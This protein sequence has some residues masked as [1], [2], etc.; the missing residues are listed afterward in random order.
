MTRKTVR[1]LGAVLLVGA[2]VGS[3]GCTAM[4]RR[5]ELPKEDR[6]RTVERDGATSVK[7]E[8]E[9]AVG[10][11]KVGSVSDRDVAMDGEFVYSR[12]D[13]APRVGY[14]L[15]GEVG[16]L[17]VRQDDVRGSLGSAYH[18][19]WDVRL[20]DDLPIDLSVELGVGESELNLGELQLSRLDAD[21]GVG[22]ATIDLSG[23]TEDLAA[24]IDCGTGSVTLR[25]PEN[26]GVRIVG[27]SD[28]IGEYSA[29]GFEQD[30]DALVN[31]AYEKD[32]AK[33]DIVLRRGVGD[34]RI[35]TVP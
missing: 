20:P 11:L 15:D 25:V 17:K 4:F 26:V 9:M 29:P 27:Q 35:E 10:E 5:V 16:E 34:V 22:D 18:N 24:E 13:W 28:G 23:L 3:T 33:L 2:L 8:I 1:A 31:D 30:G 21:L 12:R 14:R 32:G 19:E 6:Q 7:A